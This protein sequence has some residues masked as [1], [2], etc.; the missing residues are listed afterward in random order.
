MVLCDAIINKKLKI[1]K[2]NKHVLNLARLGISSG[3]ICTIL[4][5]NKDFIIVFP[6]YRNAVALDCFVASG[7]EIDYL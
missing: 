3:A 1:I 2:V 7:V 4:K 6:E 5:K